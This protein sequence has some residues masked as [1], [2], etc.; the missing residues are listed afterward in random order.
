ME[1]MYVRWP[2]KV[3]QFGIILREEEVIME[4]L[5]GIGVRPKWIYSMSLKDQKR[6]MEEMSRKIKREEGKK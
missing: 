2:E 4:D 5:E 1:G 6:I 3:Y